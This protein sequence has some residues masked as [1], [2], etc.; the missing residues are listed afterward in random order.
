MT[1]S[2]AKVIVAHMR[3]PICAKAPDMSFAKAPDVGSAKATHVTP[4]KA[5]HVASA[6]TTVSAA[7]AA[8]GLCTRGNKTAGKQR[9]CQN[10]DYSSSHY[11]LRLN[12]RD[13]PPLGFVRRLRV[14]ARK[15]PTSRWTEGED[16]DSWFPLN[17]RSLIQIQ[18]RARLEANLS[19]RQSD[20]WTFNGGEY[21]H[22]ISATQPG[23]PSL[24]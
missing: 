16:A 3:H 13:C 17:S 2:N 7:T 14:P 19:E 4:A 22:A 8:A 10:H 21:T 20:S 15:P 9:T 18:H 23:P 12:G 11:I 24:S 1:S 6:T 5:A